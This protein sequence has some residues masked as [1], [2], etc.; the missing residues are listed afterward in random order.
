VDF[1][2]ARLDED[3]TIARQAGRTSAPGA[4]RW[5]VDGWN[6]WTSEDRPELIGKVVP[7]GWAHHMARHD[8][9]RVLQQCAMLRAMLGH[10]KEVGE[11]ERDRASDLGYIG[12]ETGAYTDDLMY[13]DI[14]AVWSDH[15]D[16]RPEWAQG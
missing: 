8:P 4:D 14:A 6:L 10:A 1:I 9:A 13:R 12:R 2:R 16:Y 15:P 3:E 11:Y 5:Q 7:L